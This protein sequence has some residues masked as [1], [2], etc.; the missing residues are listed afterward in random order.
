M[1]YRFA[2]IF[3]CGLAA[4]S[5]LAGCAAPNGQ[6]L[7]YTNSTAAPYDSDDATDAAACGAIGNCPDN[8]PVRLG[9]HDGALGF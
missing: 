9:P 3:A 4:A 7:A 2:F 6:N 1:S 8:N 5:S